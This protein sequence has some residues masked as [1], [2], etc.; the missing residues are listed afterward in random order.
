MVFRRDAE[1]LKYLPVR[2]SR[3]VIDPHPLRKRALFQASLDG[4][5]QIT[6]FFR[7]EFAMICCF[8]HWG[9]RCTE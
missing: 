5:K 2:G 3:G 7:C 6:Q 8:R 1:H 9:V 4:C